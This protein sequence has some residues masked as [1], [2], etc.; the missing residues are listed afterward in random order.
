MGDKRYS[1]FI[2]LEPE[3]KKADG[4]IVGSREDVLAWMRAKYGDELLD[5]PG[6]DQMMHAAAFFYKG[7]C[8]EFWLKS[9]GEVYLAEILK[10]ENDVVEDDEDDLFKDGINL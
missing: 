6:E 2:S 3:F 4:A 10:T 7:D 8:S 9:G 5:D 1:C